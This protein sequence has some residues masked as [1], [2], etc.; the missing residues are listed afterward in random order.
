M[1][2]I[3]Y[4]ILHFAIYALNLFLVTVTGALMGLVPQEVE[5]SYSKFPVLT[6]YQPELLSASFLVV[7]LTV[8]GRVIIKEKD[9]YHVAIYRAVLILA[10]LATYWSDSRF[11]VEPEQFDLSRSLS[12][13]IIVAVYL[14]LISHIFSKIWGRYTGTR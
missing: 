4:D 14:A 12:T 1:K 6:E 11:Y 7:F 10:G 2:R 13:I 5:R 8:M 3:L 9:G